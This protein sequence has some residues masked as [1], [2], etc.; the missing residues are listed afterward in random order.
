MSLSPP[1]TNYPQFVYLFLN[2]L[3]S[4]W[5]ILKQRGQ[6]P[7]FKRNHPIYVFDH[8]FLYLLYSTPGPQSA[9]NGGSALWLRQGVFLPAVFYLTLLIREVPSMFPPAHYQIPPEVELNTQPKFGSWNCLLSWSLY[10][11]LWFLLCGLVKVASWVTHKLIDE[12]WVRK[13]IFDSLGKV[14]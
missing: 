2:C 10:F 12:K 9:R 5:F 14:E 13:Q 4:P 11:K 7:D 1:T 6:I 8:I 3:R